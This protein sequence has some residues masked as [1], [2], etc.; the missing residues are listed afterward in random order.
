MFSLARF[1]IIHPSNLDVYG[2]GERV[3]HHVIKTLVTHGQ[4]VELLTFDFDRRRYYEIIGDKFPDIPV[5]TLGKKLEVK[6]PF[7]IYK[8]RSA[9]DNLLKQ[10]K[11]TVSQNYDYVFLT[12][13]YSAS[14]SSSLS[15]AEKNIAYVHFPE[16]HFIYDH[17]GVRRKA[18]LL[19]YRW[20]VNRGVKKLD[21]IF[22]NSGYTKRTIEKYW[23]KFG[24]PEPIVIYPPVE[25]G[26]FWCDRSL[27]DRQKRVVYVGRFISAKKHELIKKL[28]T[29]IPQF[30]FVSVGGLR[31]TEKEWFEG[32][33][34]TSQSTTLLNP[35]CQGRI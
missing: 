27:K 8:R 31:D 35:T 10:F 24:V 17:S 33:Q 1:L 21:L 23:S 13:W 30:E 2:G 29:G 20:W 32:S 6:P 28:A 12:Q 25:V 5:H 19:M 15:R 22:C 18:Y 7:S 9:M 4:D 11:K 14:E 3:C 26:E 34:K 16:I